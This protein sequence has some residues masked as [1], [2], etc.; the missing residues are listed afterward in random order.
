MKHF[1]IVALLVV[2]GLVFFR[3]PGIQQKYAEMVDRADTRPGK[4]ILFV[5]NSRTYYHDMPFMVRKIADSAKAADKYR[6]V[7][8]APGE[9]R[10][11]DHWESGDI[12][13]MMKEKW[14]YVVLQGRGN[15]Q[16]NDATDA[17]FGTYGK[18]L[19]DMAK[20]NGATPVLFVTWRYGNDH[21]FYQTHPELK[22]RIFW[23]MQSSHNALSQNTGAQKVNVGMAWERLLS[24][25]PSFR[26]YEDGNHP[27]IHGSYLA[28]LMFYKFFAAA[29]LG[30]VTYVPS[31]IRQEDAEL[32]RK[33][34][35]ENY[36]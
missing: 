15:E 11:Q 25:N 3:L 35:N 16:Q 27:T 9:V 13:N 6:I 26:L 2:F 29:D 10:L 19:I 22:D 18:Q 14:D 17:S 24:Y 36:F 7:M 8:H 1:R 30:N 20:F 34:A 23:R 31:G 21:E 4:K 5:G 33:V 28:A 32:I 12:R